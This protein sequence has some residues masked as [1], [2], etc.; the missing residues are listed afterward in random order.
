MSCAPLWPQPG[1]EL[2]TSTCWWSDRAEGCG[3]EISSLSSSLS[4]CRGSLG[5]LVLLGSWLGKWTDTC[6]LFESAVLAGMLV[7]R[8]YVGALMPFVLNPLSR[9]FLFHTSLVVWN[10]S[11]WMKLSPVIA[12]P[13][14]LFLGS[15]PHK[16]LLGWVLRFSEHNLLMLHDCYSFY[17]L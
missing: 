3:W 9:A 10:L 5:E 14:R 13:L 15:V 1:Q 16:Y 17:F 6:V 8:N 2:H 11:V 12:I 4:C 7:S